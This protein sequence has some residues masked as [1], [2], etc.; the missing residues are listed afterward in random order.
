MPPETGRP[1]ALSP[2]RSD[3]S[4]RFGAVRVHG[5]S[6]GPCWVQ[7]VAPVDPSDIARTI[8]RF[9]RSRCRAAPRVAFRPP[10][11]GPWQGTIRGAAPGPPPAAP[12]GA[13][14]WT[15]GMGEGVQT[16]APQPVP[17][18]RSLFE[19]CQAPYHLR[20]TGSRCFSARS[21]RGQWTRCAGLLSSLAFA[22]DGTLRGLTAAQLGRR[23]ARDER[24]TVL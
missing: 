21:I 15:G 14:V 10:S 23:R 20:G 6:V 13:T 8:S 2:S 18:V 16:P 4:C 19:A 24:P 1:S 11:G 7:A 9:P 3:K 12:G 22:T 17:T 5:S